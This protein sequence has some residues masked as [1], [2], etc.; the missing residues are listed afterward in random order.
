MPL[1]RNREGTSLSGI[2]KKSESVETHAMDED[3]AV[4]KT[5]RNQF[6]QFA[7]KE[8]GLENLNPYIRDVG[9]GANGT[10]L[11]GSRT[12]PQNFAMMQ[13]DHVLR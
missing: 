5:G 7:F 11:R 13:N 10:I 3:Y 12:P 1:K 8:A 9:P 2:G 4:N 6:L